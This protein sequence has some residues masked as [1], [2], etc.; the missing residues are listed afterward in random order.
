MSL[1][2]LSDSDER[3]Y[4]ARLQLERSWLSLC[5]GFKYPYVYCNQYD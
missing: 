3:D 5:F 4:P 1:H 2:P